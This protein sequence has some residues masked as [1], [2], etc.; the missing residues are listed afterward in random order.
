MNNIFGKYQIIMGKVNYFLF[1]ISVFLLPFPQAY[2]RYTW[3]AWIATWILEGR[4]LV[5]ENINPIKKMLPFLFFGGWYLWKI[6][7]GLWSVDIEAYKW[8]LERYMFF[9]LLIPVSIWG[10]NAHYN[11]KQICRVL[12]IGCILSA[13][14]YAF[15]LYWVNNANV[16]YKGLIELP[17]QDFTLAFFAD[18][19]SFIKHRLFLCSTMMM[20]IMA[21]LYIRQ[22]ICEKY[23]STLGWILI[24]L[25]IFILGS[26]ILATGSRAS[27][28]SGSGLIIVALLYKLPIRKIRYKIAFIVF[29]LA[30]GTFALTQHPR[31]KEV[32]LRQALRT[33]VISKEQNSRLNIWR[34]ALENRAEYSAYGIGAG[35]SFGY[36][37]TKYREHQIYHYRQHNAHN[38]YLEEWIEIGIPGMIFFILA[39]TSILYSAT[40]AGRKTAILLTSLYGLNMLTDCM[41]G[42]FDGIA[43]WVTVMILILLQSDTQSHQ[44]PTGDTQ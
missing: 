9:G 2:A 15:T 13:F 33:N 35:Q 14:I 8:L 10:V 43:L 30:I 12:V 24:C 20:G 42:R 31:M 32:N 6:I 25:S 44:Q 22:D 41:F 40:Y 23:G 11:W 34:I 3:I 29:A 1:L 38:Q 39:W 21:L 28:L 27:I 5:K 26:L 19:I 7:S 16:F 36:L 18:K 37:Q 17:Q 4:F